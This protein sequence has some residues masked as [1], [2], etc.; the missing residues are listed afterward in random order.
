MKKTYIIIAFV[1]ITAFLI[2]ISNLLQNGNQTS[3]TD[4]L[5]PTPLPIAEFEATE[6]ETATSNIPADSKQY[7]ATR[8]KIADIEESLIRKE[9]AVGSLLDLLPYQGINFKIE[10]DYANT[11]Y[12]VT[13]NKGKEKEGNEEFNNFLKQNGVAERSWIRDNLLVIRYE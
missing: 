2:F 8:E 9:A 6:T 10:N 13:V 3:S 5:S 7:K 11:Q 12:V 4:L 1:V